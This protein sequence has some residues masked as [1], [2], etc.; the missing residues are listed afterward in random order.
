MP[1]KFF[2]KERAFKT[3][4]QNFKA[5]TGRQK[6]HCSFARQLNIFDYICAV[7]LATLIA[8]LILHF[9]PFHQEE[10]REYIC[11]SDCTE[12]SILPSSPSCTYSGAY[13]S[14]EYMLSPA[15]SN[16]SSAQRHTSSPRAGGPAFKTSGHNQCTPF[17]NAILSQRFGLRIREGES[18]RYLHSLCRLNL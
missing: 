14:G 17:A 9:L 18:V 2:L 7:K 12:S 10:V 5:R 8:C 4:R 16:S 6:Q 13:I 1:A 15:A 11:E 3:G